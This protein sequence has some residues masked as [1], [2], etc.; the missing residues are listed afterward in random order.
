MLRTKIFHFLAEGGQSTVERN[1]FFNSRSAHDKEIDEFIQQLSINGHTFVN[2]NSVAYGRFEP[3]N[4]IRTI[5]VYIE[6]PTR[7]VLVEKINDKV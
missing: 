6:N 5:I 2:M 3:A 7:K 1:K 4:R